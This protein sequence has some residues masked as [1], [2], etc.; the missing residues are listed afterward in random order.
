[1]IMQKLKISTRDIVLIPMFTALTA[2]FSQISIPLQPVPINLATLS[3]FIAGGI[4]GS[5]KGGLS[6]LIYVLLGAFG[7]PVF[8]GL[9]GGN[10][11]GKPTAGYILGY[12]IAAIVIGFLIDKF[13]N[14]ILVY[15][16]AMIL[17]M[18][19]YYILGTAWFMFVMK[20]DF[21]YAFFTCVFPFLLGDLLK[22]ILAVFLIRRLENIVKVC[23]ANN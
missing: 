16:I 21:M 2:V 12:I 17:G 23:Y 9:S 6:Q 20:V 11:F 15:Y 14:V 5:I 22:A 13:H 10:L 3:V 8:A 19:C 4:L 18:L 7:V 1:M